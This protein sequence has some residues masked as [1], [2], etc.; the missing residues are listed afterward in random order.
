MLDGR[1]RAG[2]DK[3]TEPIGDALRRAGATANELTLLGLVMGVG[4]ALAIGTGHLVWGVVLLIGSGLPDLLDGPVA[5]SGG[6]ASTRGAFFD[7]VADRVTDALLFGGTAWYLVSTG[8]GH[9]A[10]L[11]V[12]VLAAAFLVSYQRAKAESLGIDARG[13][14]MERAERM[15]VLAA[16]L[17]FASLLLVPLLWL[18]LA[19]TL[20]TAVQ[21]FVTVWRQAEAPPPRPRRS[22]LRWREGRA[23]SRFRSWRESAAIR[24]SRPDRA[25]TQVSRWRSRRQGVLSS[26]ASRAGSR[27]RHRRGNAAER[28]SAVRSP[29]AGRRRMSEAL[30]RR[31]DDG[32]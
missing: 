32:A 29:G 19:L 20:A 28:A 13:G 30:R 10:L 15:I 27:G 2:V 6:T 31:L 22:E 17:A 23:E 11:P 21:R 24:T 18:L 14:V 5:K 16:A 3:G 7:S 8:R 9:L 4:A 25:G 1:W 26:R 12:A